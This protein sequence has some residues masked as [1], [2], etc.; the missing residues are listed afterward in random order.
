MLTA[1]GYALRKNDKFTEAIA[2]L[3]QVVRLAP[4]DV[5]ALYLLG[6]TYLMAAEHDEAITTLSKILELKPERGRPG[7]GGD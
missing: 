5:D 4:N 1:L 2:P 3:R 7:M 6:N